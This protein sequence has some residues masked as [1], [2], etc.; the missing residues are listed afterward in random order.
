MNVPKEQLEIIRAAFQQTIGFSPA[1]P[2][3]QDLDHRYELDPIDQ[4]LERYEF[5]FNSMELVQAAKTPADWVRVAACVRTA[6]QRVFQQV[7][8]REGNEIQCRAGCNYCCFNYPVGITPLE[9]FALTARLQSG[10]PEH[11]ERVRARI[12]PLKEAMLK[13]ESKARRRF[14]AQ[15]PLLE[16][17]E[18]SVYEDRPFMCIRH[19]SFNVEA[20]KADPKSMTQSGAIYYGLNGMLHEVEDAIEERGMDAE[21]YEM[22]LA[23]CDALENPK[24]LERWLHLGN[25]FHRNYITYKE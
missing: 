19:H 5:L 10:P 25:A 8:E 2:Q 4:I 15:C 21:Y 17:G 23:L 22:L 9:V 3:I 6:I 7:K 20:C 24:H 16:D 11:L 14:K 13:L 1:D 18:C 12:K